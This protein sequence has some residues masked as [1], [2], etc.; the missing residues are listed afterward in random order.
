MIEGFPRSGN[1]FAVYAFEQAQQRNVSVAHHLHAPAQV[2]RATR[3][4]IPCLVLI[5]DPTDAAL[6]LVIRE[7]HISLPQAFR[8]YIS[9]YETV[10]EC[11]G[12]YVLGPFEEVVSDY[13][14]VLER[15][16]RHFGTEFRTF[17][18]TEE[19]VKEVFDIIESSHRAKRDRVVEEKISRPSAA[20]EERKT[21]LR[22]K[23]K[24]PGVEALAGRAEAVYRRL[25]SP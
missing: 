18:H 17:D 13:G 10:A 2:M 19:N 16:N 14:A 4:Q 11:G 22:E 23:L 21:A 8:H 1:T 25:T 7:P 12:G 24:A 3:W 15:V 6:S 20:K 9:F 5:R